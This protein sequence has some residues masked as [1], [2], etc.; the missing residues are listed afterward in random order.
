MSEREALRIVNEAGE[1]LAFTY[2]AGGPVEGCSARTPPDDLVVIGHGVTSDRDRPWSEA[3]STAL[4]A[5]G[6]ASIRIAFAG[7]GESEGRFEAATI[8]KEVADLGAVLGSF[9]DRRLHYVGHSMGGAVGLVRAS[10]PPH[11]LAGL[12]RRGDSHGRVRAPHV[13]TPAAG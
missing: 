1:R 3:L 5:E 9:P 8:T 4:A 6:I 13:R 12:A 2:T 11:P 10:R 7:N